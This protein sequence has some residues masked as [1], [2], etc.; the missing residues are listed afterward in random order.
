M[1]APK[2]F[3][4]ALV[5]QQGLN[6]SQMVRVRVNGRG[7]TPSI[8]GPPEEMAEVMAGQPAPGSSRG[9]FVSYLREQLDLRAAAKE[10]A[11]AAKK[12]ERAA[13]AAAQQ[14]ALAAKKEERAAAAA[15]KKEAALAAKKDERAAAAAAAATLTPFVARRYI[16]LAENAQRLNDLEIQPTTEF[17]A[18]KRVAD[19]ARGAAA[20]LPAATEASVAEAAVE[21]IELHFPK[22]WKGKRAR[23]SADVVRRSDRLKGPAAA[24]SFSA[25]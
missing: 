13:A 17:E 8:T 16:T 2:D 10:A 18:S 22:R 9:E 3:Q 19:I 4:P 20:A 12:E 24:A 6:G 25:A 5:Q 15:A 1:P 14:A 23:E 7:P 21:A 11:L